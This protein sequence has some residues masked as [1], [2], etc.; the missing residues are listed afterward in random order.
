MSRTMNRQ[1]KNKKRQFHKKMF[2]RKSEKDKRDLYVLTCTECHQAFP[3][4]YFRGQIREFRMCKMCKKK[5]PEICKYLETYVYHPKH[6][7]DCHPYQ[8][9][10]RKIIQK[11]ELLKIKLLAHNH[12]YGNKPASSK[13]DNHDVNAKAVQLLKSL[14]YKCEIVDKELGSYDLYKARPVKGEKNAEI[15]MEQ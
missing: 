12:Q 6:I 13:L 4:R 1:I 9:R 14:I 10:L 5:N 8:M 7:H 2:R 11:C 15:K 3:P